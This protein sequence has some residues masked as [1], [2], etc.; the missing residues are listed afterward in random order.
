M[1]SD[2]ECEIRD[3]LE[4]LAAEVPVSA[5]ERLRAHHYRPRS[6]RRRAVM[7]GS[8]VALALVAALLAGLLDLGTGAQRA[9][10]GWAPSPTAPAIGQVAG[11][12]RACRADARA[13]AQNPYPAARGGPPPRGHQSAPLAPP[14]RTVLVDT[15]GPYT[16]VILT[17]RRSE[18]ACFVG[19][20]PST[21]IISRS[22]GS[23]VGV[24]PPVPSGRIVITSSARTGAREHRANRGGSPAVPAR[25]EMA[26]RAGPG[27]RSIRFRL[28]DH[29]A[30][31]AT[32]ANGWFLAWWPTE[33]RA[34]AA[35]V[36]TRNG[37]VTTPL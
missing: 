4:G 31:T 6:P 26:G 33:A 21:H 16:A 10:A 12:E 35:Q 34:V 2:F 13:A 29:T 24:L 5:S 3:A 27:V 36:N 30:V 11:A 1:R 20:W 9:W 28:S 19:P 25:T 17:S 7:F 14:R 23:Y 15:R 18:T 22:G 8:C 32:T 37:S